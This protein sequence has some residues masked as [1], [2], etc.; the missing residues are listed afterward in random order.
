MITVDWR[1]MVC[2]TNHKMASVEER[3]PLQLGAE[4]IAKAHA[5]FGC[6]SG[7]ME[8]VIVST[9]NRIEFYAVA[10]VEIDPLEAV[11]EFY[12]SFRELD[13]APMTDKLYSFKGKH[14]VEHLFGVAAGIDSMVLG[15]N[16]I[17]G[18]LRD[19]YG[20]ACSVRTAGKIL[21]RLFHHAFRIGKQVRTDTEMGKGAC[22][23][24]SAATELLKSQ[25]GPSDR[26]SIMFVGVNKMI[27]MA[28]SAWGKRHHAELLFVNRTK[29]K[30]DELAAR[31]KT[32]GHG[33]DELPDLLPRVDIL[34]SCTG[35]PGTVI[36]RSIIDAAAAARPDRKLIIMDMAIPRDVEY[37]KGRQGNV[38]LFDL[39]D[40]KEFLR[41]RQLG[42]QAA[43]PD[44]RKLIDQRLNEF[45]YWYD[46]ARY[47]LV[48]NGLEHA[49]TNITEQEMGP[50]L[51]K[52]PPEQR[53]EIAQATDRLAR[54][55]AQVKL[56]AD[57]G[58][59]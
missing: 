37:E 45:A 23:V 51:E 30:A 27:S 10:K 7:I 48:Y 52:L 17:L 16:Q 8:A 12:H 54:R 40:I 46:H 34:V 36:D 56:R 18:Q 21:H 26:P 41:E 38:T 47:E 35:A 39:E 20:S 15:E 13:L 25:L 28:A 24:S 58:T 50:I 19:A 1:L 55:L 43:I 4:D 57:G 29:S 2:G 3:E 32:V 5:E 42:R 6:Q 53:R 49:F 11:K 33:L 9:C 44:A 14:A 22:S 31:Y 59:Q